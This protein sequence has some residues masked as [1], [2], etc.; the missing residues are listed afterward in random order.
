MTRPAAIRRAIADFIAQ[1]GRQA[2]LR[3]AIALPAILAAAAI[4][5]VALAVMVEA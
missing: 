4:A 2:T 5:L 3:E 1:E